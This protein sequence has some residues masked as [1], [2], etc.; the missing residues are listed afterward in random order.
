MFYLNFVT[1]LNLIKHCIFIINFTFLLTELYGLLLDIISKPGLNEQ[2]EIVTIKPK[3]TT[4][5]TV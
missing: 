3:L 1:V 5:G 4:K 2:L